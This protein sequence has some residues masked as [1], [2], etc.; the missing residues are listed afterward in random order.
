MTTPL[1]RDRAISFEEE[2]KY[3][4]SRGPNLRAL[5]VLAVDTGMRQ[6]SELFASNG[7]KSTSNPLKLWPTE[8]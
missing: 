5:T 6:K 7:H 2:K 4:E 3:L 8:R 1:H